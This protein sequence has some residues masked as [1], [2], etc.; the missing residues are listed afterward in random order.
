[1]STVGDS[2]REVVTFD[3]Y[4]T[5]VDFNLHPATREILSDRFDLDGLNVEEFLD[6]FRVMRFQA[7]L[8]HYRPYGE[9]LRSSLE[10]AMRLH[11]LDYRESDGD[12]L[13][14]AFPDRSGKPLPESTDIVVGGGGLTG[15]STALH[16]ARNGA[17]VV[18]VELGAI[19]SG[20]S[21]RNGS[22]CTQGLTIGV[23]QAVKRYGL[24]R[25]QELY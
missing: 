23:G 20:A 25:A 6:D 8:G 15:L 24:E 7:V 22:M 11:G 3:A 9:V 16:T 4:G 5:L 17:S 21:T 18:L 10:I 1:M 2:M 13:G 12:A 19:G 14:A